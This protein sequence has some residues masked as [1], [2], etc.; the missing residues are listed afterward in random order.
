MP[1]LTRR[2]SADRRHKCWHIY[3][4][5]FHDG[6]IAE[7]VGNPHDTDQ[8][9]QSC[10]FYPGS[11]PGEISSD[12]AATF[13]EAR[14]D[15]ARMAGVFFETNRGRFSVVSQFEFPLPTRL[16][17]SRFGEVSLPCRDR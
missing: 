17:Y 11:K 3:Y 6:T 7:R 4:G 2:R 10:G 5:D 13:E 14:A 12:T 15:F 16:S 9:Q 1:E 8:W